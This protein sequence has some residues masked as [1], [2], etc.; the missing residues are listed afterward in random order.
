MALYNVKHK[1]LYLMQPVKGGKPKLQ[2]VT[3]ATVELDEKT[4]ESH[5]KAKRLVL[6]TEK[7]ATVTTKKS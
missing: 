1:N 2:K 4:A 5:V 3:T 6:A 7:P